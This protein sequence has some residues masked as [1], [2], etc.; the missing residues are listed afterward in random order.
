[1]V[2]YPRPAPDRLPLGKRL[3][4]R[5]FGCWPWGW[6]GREEGFK[7]P[8]RIYLVRCGRCGRYFLDYKHGYEE[9]F[10]CPFCEGGR[11]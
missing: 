2:P 9:Y 5:L 8:T 6:A 1:V 3:M 11:G 4:T 7:L 10:I